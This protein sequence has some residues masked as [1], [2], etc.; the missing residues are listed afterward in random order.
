MFRTVFFKGG[1]QEKGGLFFSFFVFLGVKKFKETAF[2]TYSFVFPF[3]LKPKLMKT[4]LSEL[5]VE[6][7]E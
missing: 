3:K 7:P 4:R 5:G 6:G 2:R 1:E